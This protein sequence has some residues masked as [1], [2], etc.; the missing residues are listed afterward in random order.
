MVTV[1]HLKFAS[2][3]ASSKIR[4]FRRAPNMNVVDNVPPT[5]YS[6]TKVVS[7]G[8]M[9]RR[10]PTNEPIFSTLPTNT[11]KTEMQFVVKELMSSPMR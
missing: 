3:L 6:N 5:E 11:T 10:T 7:R 9:D 4:C 8:D 1:L 2:R